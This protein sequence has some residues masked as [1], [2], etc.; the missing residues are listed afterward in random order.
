MSAEFGG[1][2]PQAQELKA[3][4]DGLGISILTGDRS[5]NSSDESDTYNF[6]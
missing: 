5:G 4:A 6:E 3:V 1:G 2:A